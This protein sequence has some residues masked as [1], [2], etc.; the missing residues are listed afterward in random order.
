MICRNVQNRNLNGNK[1][2]N[3]YSGWRQIAQN[4]KLDQCFHLWC[5]P[6]NIKCPMCQR[7]ARTGWMIISIWRHVRKNHSVF[8]PLIAGPG[9]PAVLLLSFED[10]DCESSL[11]RLSWKRSVLV[12]AGR[13]VFSSHICSQMENSSRQLSIIVSFVWKHQ[14]LLDSTRMPNC[15]HSLYILTWLCFT[16]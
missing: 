6:L 16:L 3:L 7:S 13:C 5:L 11:F 1:R 12:W 14:Q 9:V 8:F 10:V 4:L 15:I 2:P